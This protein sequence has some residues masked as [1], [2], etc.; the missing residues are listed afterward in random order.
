MV[1]APLPMNINRLQSFLGLVNYY[2]KFV[3]S[4]STILSP[5]YDLLTKGS[6]WNWTDEH[7]LAFKKF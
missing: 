6:K 5:L 1:E 7:N 3:P 2:K 4:S